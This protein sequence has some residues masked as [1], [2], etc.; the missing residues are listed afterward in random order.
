MEPLTKLK[1]NGRESLTTQQE[2][3]HEEKISLNDVIEAITK[4]NIGKVPEI[5]KVRPKMIKYMEDEGVELLYETIKIAWNKHKIHKDWKMAIIVPIFKKE[6]LRI[7]TT[8]EV[9]Y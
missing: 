1:I 7:T 4:I 3:E 2:T 5:D 8:I 6:K 9:R